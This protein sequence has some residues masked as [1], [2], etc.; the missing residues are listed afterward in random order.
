MLRCLAGICPGAVATP[1]APPQV[2]L[3]RLCRPTLR[4]GEAYAPAPGAEAAALEECGARLGMAGAPPGADPPLALV[5]R[6]F[7][8]NSARLLVVVPSAGAPRGVWDAALAEGGVGAATSPPLLRWAEANGFAVALF[9]GEGPH[10]L[11][12]KVWDGVLK[13]SPAGCASV[14]VAGGMLPALEAA[15]DQLHP[16]LFSRFR[17]VCVAPSLPGGGEPSAAPGD[18]GAAVEVSAELRQHLGKAL[19]RLPPEWARQDAFSAHQQLFE[20]LLRR[21][22]F[23]SQ[24]EAKK[25]AGFRDLKENDVPG[26]RRIGIDKRVERITRDRGNDEL[27]QLMRKHERNDAGVGEEDEPGVD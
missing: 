19:L 21:E 12:P 18:G 23:W 14:L 7:A 2:D 5:S 22:D 15:M 25:Y 20:A 3:A 16:L 11:S 4:A 8:R 24:N 27:S 9:C 13:G 17:S 6:D 1:S 26:L 10:G